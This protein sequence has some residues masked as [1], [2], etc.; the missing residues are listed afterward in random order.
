MTSAD[1]MDTLQ[2]GPD[3][4]RLLAY[5][6]QQLSAMLDGEL[7][8]DQAKFMLRRLQH[9]GELA[10]NWERW[11]VCGDMLRGRHHALLPRDFADRVS[12]AI[13][14][15][16]D[17]EPVQQ[18]PPRS[19]RL[20]RWGGGAALAASVALVAVFATRQ[21]PDPLQQPLPTSQPAVA[22]TDAGTPMTAGDTSGV[23][24]DPPATPAPVVA[25][26][27]PM[28]LAAALAASELPKR[29]NADRRGRNPSRQADA[30][31]RAVAAAAPEPI[32]LA[33]VDD[34]APA[35]VVAGNAFPPPPALLQPRPWPRAILP[36]AGDASFAVGHGRLSTLAP[37]AVRFDPFRPRLVEPL[38]IP[39]QAA[40]IPRDVQRDPVDETP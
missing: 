37:D 27:A 4:D 10:A 34:T 19:P 21:L 3:P 32:A 38:V 31:S 24:V 1:D 30:S 8:P 17:A 11:Q 5:H 15:E 12:R 13:S 18:T 33:S 39:P 6:R 20:L 16:T 36:G 9:D 29:R 28:V 22:S 23:P 35:A 14:G 26:A 7:S 25:D 40:A 2:I